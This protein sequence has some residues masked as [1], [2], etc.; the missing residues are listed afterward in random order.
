MDEQKIF[1]YL[2]NNLE[3]IV[4]KHRW[5]PGG[6][7]EVTLTIKLNNPSTQLPEVISTTYFTVD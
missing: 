6:T 7:A 5:T 2:K 4:S 1:D 3:F